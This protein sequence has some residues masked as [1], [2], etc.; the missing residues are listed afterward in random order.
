[1]WGE[2]KWVALIDRKFAIVNL[3]SD[4]DTSYTGRQDMENFI[5]FMESKLTNKQRMCGNK[6]RRNSSGEWFN[7]TI[8]LREV[9]L[10]W[11]IQKLGRYFFCLWVQV[12]NLLVVN[13]GSSNYDKVVWF[14]QQ[15]QEQIC[16]GNIIKSWIFSNFY[17]DSNSNRQVLEK[18]FL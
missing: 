4:K 7:S 17:G 14:V 3:L 12:I 13:L 8:L 2:I 6:R 16:K 11:T 10:Q 5:S 9:L 15:I 1:M 18:D